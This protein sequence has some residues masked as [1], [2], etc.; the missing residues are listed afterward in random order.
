MRHARESVRRLHRRDHVR[1][2]HLGGQAR[3]VVF[4]VEGMDLVAQIL[5]ADALVARVLG[6]E[7]GH[8]PPQGL[9]AVIV[10]LELLQL[11]HHRV[12]AALGDADGEH[13]EERVQA[14]L[15][16]DD[17]V[18][19][20]VLGDDRRRDTGM[21]GEVAVHVQARGDDRGLDRVEDVEAL[22]QIAEAVP[23]LARLQRPVLAAADTLF[24]QELGPPHLEPPV[25]VAEVGVHLAHRAPELDRL[26]QRFVDQR[27]SARRFHHRRRHVA[28]RDDR[29]L[30]RGRG[31]HQVGLVEDVAVELAG[32][33]VL[34]QDLRGLAQAGEQ[35]V[36][37]LGREH[38]RLA[39]ART[40]GTDRVVITIEVVEGRMRQPGFVEMQGVDLAVEHVLD[41]LDVVH[42]AVV[43]RLGDGEDAW[44]LVL[45]LACEGVGR[46]LLL[47]VLHRELF[48]R[49]RTDDAVVVA[50]RG[51]EH[52]HR[53]GHDDRVEDG[54]VA[55]AV[56]DDDVAGRHRGVPDHLVRG[57]GAVGDEVKVVAVED[58]RRVALRGRHWPGVV[59]QLAELVDRVAHVRAQHVLAEELVEHLSDRAL[60]EGD[61][62]RVPGAVP[63][64][65]AVGGVMHQRA[66][67]RRRQRLEVVL[68]LAHHV[69]RDELRRVLEHVDEAVHLAQHVVG[70]VARGARLAVQEDRDVCVAE[71][72]LHDEGAQVGDGLG[73]G[74][75]RG[76]LLVV[77]RQDEG[78]A[79]ALLLRE[80]GQVAV[81]G[82]AE[83]FHAL[84]LDRLGE[85]A[86]PQT[87]RVLGTE[88]L[89]DDD[90]G[91]ME[92]HPGRL[93]RVLAGRKSQK[94]NPLNIARALPKLNLKK[95]KGPSGGPVDSASRRV[96]AQ[97]LGSV[98]P[99]W[100]RYLPPRSLYEVSHTS[101][102]SKNSICA[103]P[104]L[105]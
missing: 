35:L 50:R 27:R 1:Q 70:D 41:G 16:D 38:H 102:D 94:C 26:G 42:H 34:H 6:D 56:D 95:H 77:D 72:D 47:D 5:E 21:F 82:H 88:V 12:P 9:V 68:R 57:R 60:Q 61:A 46:D 66:E 78:R 105:A 79:A 69:A 44:L 73:R 51:Q 33:R 83:H 4:L 52:R 43:G 93:Q 75:G 37:R 55:V 101:S 96:G 65:R 24:S 86:D 54:L 81:A 20:Q 14:S 10:V 40:V 91:E 85:R 89:V 92:S 62:A 18:L 67:E 17:A 13:D 39:A 7:L 97:I 98:T 49:D 8:H 58:A 29:V 63:R 59:E 25:V 48:E 64:I 32:L 28:R 23:A 53:A 76:E 3:D 99:V 71:A 103:T 87:G 31:V 84:F 100:P 74:L 80:R 90:D 2:V 104:S 15:L 36:G 30:R 22:G 19:G 11:G 45:R